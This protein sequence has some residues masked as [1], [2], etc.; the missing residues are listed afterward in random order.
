M[1]SHVVSISSTSF[2]VVSCQAVG[3]RARH[4]FSLGVQCRCTILFVDIWIAIQCFGFPA[5][6]CTEIHSFGRVIFQLFFFCQW[7]AA[8]DPVSRPSSSNPCIL[9]VL[10]VNREYNSI[11]G[12]N[13]L[14]LHKHRTKYDLRKYFF[15]NR[16]LDVWNSLPNH[17]VL[18]DTVNTFKSK[19]D[20]FWQQQPIICIWF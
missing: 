6:Q 5:A 16:A 7:S 12:G 2:Q 18:S 17:V 8:S 19:L 13:D 3:W 11:T 20:R 15:T 9:R 10:R 14:R 4:L 1:F